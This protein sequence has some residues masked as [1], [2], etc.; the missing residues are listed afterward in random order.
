[1]LKY[2]AVAFLDSGNEIKIWLVLN[3]I[4]RIYVS[5]NNSNDDQV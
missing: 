2:A 5:L 3:Q 4:P 1:M